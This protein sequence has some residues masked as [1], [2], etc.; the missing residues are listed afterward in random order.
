MAYSY[1]WPASLPQSPQ[2]GFVETGGV[3]VIRSPMDAGPAKQRRRGSR[4][5]TMQLTFI[6][7]TQQVSTLEVFVKDTIR[8]TSRFGFT[9]PR[10]KTIAEVRIIPQNGGELYTITYLAPEYWTISLQLEVLP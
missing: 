4:P 2:K 3:L 10:T 9:H 7:S 1:T 5:Q 8:G 6:M